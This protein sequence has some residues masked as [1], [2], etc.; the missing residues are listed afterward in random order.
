MATVQDILVPDIGDFEGVEVIEILV[1]P[2][3]NIQV[4]DPLV[5]LESDKAAMEIPSPQSGTVTQVKVAIGDKVSQGDLLITM[6]VTAAEETKA[7]KEPSAVQPEAAPA[8]PPVEQEPTTAQAPAP[9]APT[10]AQR[11][12]PILPSPIDEAGFRKAHASPSVRKFAR[13]LG[14][15]PSPPP[16]LVD[17]MIRFTKA[18]TS[19]LS[20][21]PLLPVPVICARSAPSSRANFRTEGLA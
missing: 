15:T 19:S 9:A 17:V 21:R 12:P 18:V 5:S 6:E 13:E 8:T 10:R 3:D 2:G 20:M 11:P 14:A 7:A 1:A 4:E 16:V